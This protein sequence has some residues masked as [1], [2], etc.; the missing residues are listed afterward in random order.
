MASTSA[1]II[2]S[3]LKTITGVE[4]RMPPVSKRNTF[5]CVPQRMRGASESAETSLKLCDFTYLLLLRFF[6]LE[7]QFPCVGISHQP[8]SHDVSNEV[9]QQVTLELQRNH[10]GAWRVRKYHWKT[11]RTVTANR[12]TPR[13]IQHF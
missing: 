9:M 12:L 4:R 8:D 7:L 1:D 2:N 11:A 13:L 10:H 3:R 6:R 5:T